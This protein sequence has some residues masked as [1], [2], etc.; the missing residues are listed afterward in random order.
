MEVMS[1]EEHHC[2]GG[3]IQ[4][5]SKQRAD[6]LPMVMRPVADEDGGTIYEDLPV[7]ANCPVIFLG[8][9]GY[10]IHVP[11]VQGDDCVLVFSE[12]SYSE[13]KKTGQVSKP[14]DLKRF[15]LRYPFVLAAPVIDAKIWT[16]LSGGFRIGKDGADQ[17]VQWNGSTIDV[18][19]TGAAPVATGASVADP[20]TGLVAILTT[21]ARGLAPGTVAANGAALLTSLQALALL[22]LKTTILQ[23]Q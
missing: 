14:K 2:L 8:G 15:S 10:G 20:T 13:W 9:G 18:G 17:Q 3:Q 4:K 16:T 7:I 19:A 1:S 12:Q 5:Y 11:L 22:K 6:V 23:G 21:F